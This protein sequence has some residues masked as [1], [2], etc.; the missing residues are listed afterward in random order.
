MVDAAIR[1]RIA[2]LDGLHR[3][4]P[5]TLASLQSLVDHRFTSLPDGS[6]LKPEKHYNE[7]GSVGRELMKPLQRLDSI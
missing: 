4:D 5:S 1:G 6:R 3:L 2:V 7:N